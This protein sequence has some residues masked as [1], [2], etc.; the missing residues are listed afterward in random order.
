MKHL[1]ALLFI[2]LSSYSTIWSGKNKLNLW[3]ESDI[4][5]YKQVGIGTELAVDLIPKNPSVVYGYLFVYYR[6]V[7]P[8]RFMIGKDYDGNPVFGANINWEIK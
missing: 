8:V 3:H 5:L 4:K 6:P 7:K 1:I 2:A